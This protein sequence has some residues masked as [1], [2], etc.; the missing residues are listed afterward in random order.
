LKKVGGVSALVTFICVVRTLRTQISASICNFTHYITNNNNN[1]NLTI[2]L[3]LHTPQ[4]VALCRATISPRL[5]ADA[6]DVLKNHYVALR[7]R[8]QKDQ[9]RSITLS[10]FTCLAF[11]SVQSRSLPSVNH[12]LPCLAL[13]PHTHASFLLPTTNSRRSPRFRSLCA[14][15]RPSCVCPSRWRAWRCRRS[16][17]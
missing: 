12:H 6:A 2:N 5:S 9:V 13:L 10:R 3:Q 8:V 4:Y 1:N 15:S 17:M 16:R 7:E 14:S 11:L